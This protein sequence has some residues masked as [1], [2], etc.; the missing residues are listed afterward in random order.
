MTSKMA[1]EINKKIETINKGQKIAKA[2]STPKFNPY[3][4]YNKNFS[5]YS[6]NKENKNFKKEKEL[7]NREENKKLNN[8]YIKLVK[9]SK[10]EFSLVSV[11]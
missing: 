9:E 10:I 11:L 1:N 3:I 8:K 5:Y 7:K 4:K 6:L 2:K